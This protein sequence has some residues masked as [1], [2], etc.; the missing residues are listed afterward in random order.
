[1]SECADVI[2]FPLLRSIFLYI[3]IYIYFFFAGF[4]LV[5]FIFYFLNKCCS[6]QMV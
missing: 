1:M 6:V 3:Y 4:C 5:I 2:C